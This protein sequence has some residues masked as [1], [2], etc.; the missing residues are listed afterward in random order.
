M[1]RI[2][3]TL[4]GIIFDCDGVLIDSKLANKKFYNLILQ[5]MNLPCMS[6]EQEEFVHSHTVQDSIKS[7]VPE[8]RLQEA[9]NTARNIS[10]ARVLPYIDLQPDLLHLLQV[11]QDK[12]LLLAINTNR[13]S[14][15]GMILQKFGLGHYFQPVVTSGMVNRPKPDPESLYKILGQWG[16]NPKQ[17][18]FIGDSEVDAQAAKAAGM[19]FWAYKN[20]VLQSELHVQEYAV[21]SQMLNA[22]L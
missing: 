17:A 7:L 15:M 14:T 6:Q 3:R 4:K 10:Y 12:A 22:E 21:L 2:I 5:D 13:T 18:V 1:T 20:P 16:L 19:P 8:F 11:L 9:L